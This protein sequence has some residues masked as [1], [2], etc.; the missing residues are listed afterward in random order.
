M[1]F[2]AAY[3]ADRVK[4]GTHI[5]NE[6]LHGKKAQVRAKRTWALVEPFASWR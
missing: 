2:A 4:Y 6:L 5:A 1:H 3:R